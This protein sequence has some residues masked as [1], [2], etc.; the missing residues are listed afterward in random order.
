VKTKIILHLFCCILVFAL[1]L[2]GIAMAWFSGKDTASFTS[3]ITGTVNFTVDD[4]EVSESE[5][6]G[7]CCWKKTPKN[8][9]FHWTFEN[10]GSK[11]GYLRA[12]VNEMAHIGETAW[13][14]GERFTDQGQWGMYYEFEPG[15]EGKHF[16]PLK[17]GQHYE[18]GEVKTWS[19]DDNFY[20]NVAIDSYWKISKLHLAVT[21][22]LDLIP[23]NIPN[24]PIP[25]R[26]P[27][28]EELSNENDGFEFKIPKDGEYS[29]GALE[30]ET[31]DWHNKSPLYVALHAEITKADNN[32]GGSIQWE[33]TSD[34]PDC[35]D[36]PYIWRDGRDGWWYYCGTVSPG[37]KVKLCLTAGKAEVGTYYI[38]VEGEG[39][40]ASNQARQH[41]WPN[42][43][44]D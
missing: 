39:I 42:W 40:Q 9:A 15:G 25:G 3:M 33:V 32:D 17:A 11:E 30:G 1:V 43:P 13:A 20:L 2:G 34:C 38:S 41:L 36:C 10:E 18:V 31:Y 35:S 4:G 28:K 29:R 14:K 23:T 16:T 12:R 24:N 7:T 22:C 21:D 27:F 19:D 26:F 6:A 5:K 37:E 44:C 8:W